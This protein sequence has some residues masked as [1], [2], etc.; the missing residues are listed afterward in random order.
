MLDITY[1]SSQI[2]HMNAVPCLRAFPE[3]VLAHL[4]Q[5]SRSLSDNTF[6]QQEF[7]H[8]KNVAKCACVQLHQVC[9]CLPLSALPGGCADSG[10]CRGVHP[11]AYARNE[12]MLCGM[13]GA[14]QEHGRGRGTCQISTNTFR[15]D[16]GMSR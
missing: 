6:A 1:R 2:T 16:P 5:I 11:H 9:I 8:S 4:V 7:L 14:F 13:A 15:P 12:S 10:L 3:E